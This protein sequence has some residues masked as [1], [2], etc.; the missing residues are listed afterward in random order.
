[1]STVP[2]LSLS[3]SLAL[4]TM[5]PSA[6]FAMALSTPPWRTAIE[7]PIIVGESAGKGFGAFSAVSVPLGVRVCAYHG[8][9]LT[10]AEV[11]E[12]YGG[13]GRQHSEFL[14]DCG[15]GVYIDA[16]S[17][18]H[19][20][21]FINHAQNGNLVPV[22]DGS[23]GVDFYSTRP[24][25]AGTEL[26]FDYSVSYWAARELDPLDDTRLAA[27]RWRRGLSRIGLHA[28]RWGLPI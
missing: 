7:L 24:I 11:D 27:I 8:E 1:M 2:S 16:I 19:P 22:P 23:G 9:R 6:S 10:R 28:L 3:C 18:T 25:A 4:L 15:A 20:S 17:S 14:F 21:R 12:R 5:A 26:T 13:S